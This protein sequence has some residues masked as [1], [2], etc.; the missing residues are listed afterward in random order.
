MIYTNDVIKKKNAKKI[1]LK[2]IFRFIYIS[3]FTII[4]I[5]VMYLGYMK[6]IKNEKNTGLFGFRQYLVITGSMEPK[7]NVGD[8][9][10]VREIPKEKI[11]VG[12]IIN[13]VS[14]NGTDTIT[15]R[16]TDIVELDGNTYY[17]TKGD[18]NSSEDPGF[19]DYSRVKGTVVFKI[20]KL[21]KAIT[22]LYTGTGIAVI[23]AV[24]IVSY[25]REKNKEERIIARE[26]ARKIYNVPKYEHSNSLR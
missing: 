12:D 19:V 10:I 1:L 13:Y 21:G 18:N 5:L 25:L 2:K 15:H 26:N 20:S 14:E 16:V 4:L 8:M 22:S 11:Q 7:F 23:F 17:K 3:V 9:I 24:V 6:Y